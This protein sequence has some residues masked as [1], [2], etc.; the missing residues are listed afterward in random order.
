MLFGKQRTKV[1]GKMQISDETGTCFCPSYQKPPAPRILPDSSP[2]G[3]GPSRVGV[4]RPKGCC[5]P[6]KNEIC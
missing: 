6:K 4:L 3:R 5:M 1:E 2:R